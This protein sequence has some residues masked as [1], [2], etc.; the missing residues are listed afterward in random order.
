MI[1]GPDGTI[2]EGGFF[3]CIL[4][5]PTDF[6]MSPPTMTFKSEMW[7]PNIYPDGKVCI[8][9]LHAPGED[10]MSGESSEERWRPI[11]T[12]EAVLIS[13]MS[14]LSEPNDSSPANL[15]AAVQWREDPKAYKK[16]VKRCVERSMDC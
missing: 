2:F 11:L 10:A 1:I 5:F 16:K 15:D 13:V 14:M 4:D 12:V 9:I 7:H 3:R 6:P 8:S